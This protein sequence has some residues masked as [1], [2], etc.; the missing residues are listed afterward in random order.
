MRACESS[1]PGKLFSLFVFALLLLVFDVKFFE[2]VIPMRLFIV[3]IPN[4]D[5]N[6][7]LLIWSEL[8]LANP[9]LVFFSMS[10]YIKHK[11]KAN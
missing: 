2:F 6:T 3:N 10:I 1:F 4:V 9:G 8:L 11:R 7:G 5:I